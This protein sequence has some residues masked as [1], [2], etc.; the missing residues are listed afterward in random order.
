M[1]KLLE[2]QS[3][4]EF[5]STFLMTKE[6]ADT[7]MAYAR[8]NMEAK[9]AGDELFMTDMAVHYRL[10]QIHYQTGKNPKKFFDLCYLVGIAAQR[11]GGNNDSV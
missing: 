1:L 5:A 10:K 6:Q 9:A 8:N 2:V 4:K 3:T 11:L 7:I